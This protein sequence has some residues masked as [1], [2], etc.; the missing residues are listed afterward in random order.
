MALLR[1][2]V[3]WDGK[4]GPKGPASSLPV[5]HPPISDSQRYVHV[6]VCVE[7]PGKITTQISY[8]AEGTINRINVQFQ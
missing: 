4:I 6:L 8:K 1:S 3:I 7:N 5:M 2:Q